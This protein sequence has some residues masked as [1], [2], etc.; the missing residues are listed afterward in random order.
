MRECPTCKIRFQP[1]RSYQIYCSKK[2]NSVAQNTKKRD[3]ATE[4]Q[5]RSCHKVLAITQFELAHT[6]CK[7]CEERRAAGLKLCRVCGQVKSR[8]EFHRRPGPDGHE[9][10]CKQCASE[11]SRQRNSQDGIKAKARENKFQLRYKIGTAEYQARL[12]RQ[13]GV[14]AVCQRPPST[15]LH[16]DH[17]HATG[18]V[19]DLLCSACNSILGHSRE[20]P[21]VLRAAANYLERHSHESN[22]GP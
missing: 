12:E 18:A 20:N 19:R 6:S 17:D 14:C 22:L 1:S 8:E 15:T 4:K 3:T 13:D 16:V 5:C 7:T 10:R 21:A 9:P 11:R 2:C